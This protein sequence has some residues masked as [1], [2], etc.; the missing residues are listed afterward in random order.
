VGEVT[1]NN[2]NYALEKALQDGEAKILG[3]RKAS[4]G[5]IASRLGPALGQ[6]FSK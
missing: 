1:F 6:F 4:L 2:V 5:N 3:P